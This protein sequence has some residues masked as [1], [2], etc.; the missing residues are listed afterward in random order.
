[1][2]LTGATGGIVRAIAQELAKRGASHILVGRNEESLKTLQRELSNPEHHDVVV[3]D[4]TS[5]E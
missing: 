4:N 3:A 1:I 2:L 5:S